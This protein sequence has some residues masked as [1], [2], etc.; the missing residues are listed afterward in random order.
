MNFTGTGAGV[1]IQHSECQVIAWRTSA[2]AIVAIV[3]P[4][5]FLPASLISSTCGAD[6]ASIRLKGTGWGRLRQDG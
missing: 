5:A 4:T 3:I 2:S 6:D 1:I